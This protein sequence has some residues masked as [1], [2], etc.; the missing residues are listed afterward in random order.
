MRIA[1]DYD[2]ELR[3]NI[4][5]RRTIQAEKLRK[6]NEELQ[7]DLDRIRGREGPAG[8]WGDVRIYTAPPGRSFGTETLL[9]SRDGKSTALRH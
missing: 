5:L 1:D 9:R 2:D 7:R 6:E 4:K 3:R 8:P